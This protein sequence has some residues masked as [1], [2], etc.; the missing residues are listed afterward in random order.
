MCRAWNTVANS[1]GLGPVNLDVEYEYDVEDEH[2]EEDEDWDWEEDEENLVLVLDWMLKKLEKFATVHLRSVNLEYGGVLKD[3]D[4]AYRAIIEVLAKKSPLCTQV[5]FGIAWLV[6]WSVLDALPNTLQ[7]LSLASLRLEGFAGA[8]FD[9]TNTD[10]PSLQALNSLVNLTELRLVFQGF[11]DE[12]QDYNMVVEGDLV[13][14]S[15]QVLQLHRADIGDV[16]QRGNYSPVVLAHFTGTQIP[17]NCLVVCHDLIQMS[18][19]QAWTECCWY[20]D[21]TTVLPFDNISAG[22]RLA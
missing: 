2:D 12:G 5:D 16:F 6:D 17:E 21:E 7:K 15:L 9:D 10:K 1:D 22:C 4:E 20:D 14:P 11:P 13:L 3:P 8:R 18:L 19:K